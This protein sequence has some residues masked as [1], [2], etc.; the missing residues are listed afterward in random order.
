MKKILFTIVFAS[1]FL[2]S[3]QKVDFIEY[4]LDNGLHVILHQDNSAPVV[5]AVLQYHVGSKDEDEGKKGYAHLFEHMLG[6][7]TK[8][9]DSGEWFKIYRSRGGSGNA[10]TSVDLTSYYVTL[11]SNSL[12]LA[13]WRYS[14]IMLHPVIDQ[15]SVDIQREAV[16][17]E[18]EIINLTVDFI[19]F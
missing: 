11:P 12:E 17:E 9:M 8:N 16:K 19:L 1:S 10:S 18:K 7:E 13:L 6:K 15:E 2:C 3:A 4:N 5:S 14:E